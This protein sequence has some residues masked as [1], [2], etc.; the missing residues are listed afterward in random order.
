VTAFGGGFPRPGGYTFGDQFEL[1]SRSLALGALDDLRP[2]ASIREDAHV[3]VNLFI[4]SFEAQ[5][6]VASPDIA[7]SINQS[8]LPAWQR[9]LAL[10]A[11]RHFKE[12]LRSGDER[13]ALLELLKGILS[14]DER[15]NFR[16]ALA[17]RPL[18]KAGA[19]T[20]TLTVSERAV[21]TP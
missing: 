12:R 20:A 3:G 5:A 13:T 4:E 8:Q 21:V 11:N 14:N 19:A 16:V 17:R 1:S 15:E 10:E 6:I 7:A 18:I 2:P 9:A